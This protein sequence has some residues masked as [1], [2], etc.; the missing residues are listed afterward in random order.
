ILL[1]G[2]YQIGAEQIRFGIAGYGPSGMAQ[3][4]RWNALTDW[5]TTFFPNVVRGFGYITPWNER[6]D[7]EPGAVDVDTS[8]TL[9]SDVTSILTGEDDGRAS[10]PDGSVRK[11]SPGDAVRY[12][13]EAPIKRLFI[14]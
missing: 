9:T 7:A 4:E 13:S 6:S 5:F 8:G 12:L 3:K 11:W 14:W 2:S 10:G 1:D